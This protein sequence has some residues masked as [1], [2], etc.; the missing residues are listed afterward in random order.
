MGRWLTALQTRHSCCSC[1]E[2]A[3]EHG[4]LRDPR[5]TCEVIKGP[6]NVV[7]RCSNKDTVPTD[8]LD[9]L[10]PEERL[11]LFTNLGTLLLL[12]EILLC[13][14]FGQM[15]PLGEVTA[16]DTLL[17]VV[18]C[19]TC[20]AAVV[21]HRVTGVPPCRCKEL[22]RLPRTSRQ[23]QTAR[24]GCANMAVF[25]SCVFHNTCTCALPICVHGCRWD[26]LEHAECP[27]CPVGR[28]LWP[29][30]GPVQ[31]SSTHTAVQAGLPCPGPAPRTS[32]RPAETLP[33]R[34]ANSP[35]AVRHVHSNTV[36]QPRPHLAPAPFMQGLSS[37]AT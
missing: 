22:I 15:D 19:C 20:D 12:A 8:H 33:C 14:L 16:L 6:F 29:A 26:G 2:V 3:R 13:W 31:C 21:H 24:M 35:A 7:C 30:L 25:G 9:T 36:W 28:C 32:S 18:L 23:M 4:W 10:N 37:N 11:T 17:Q 34:W 27:C 5:R 1:L